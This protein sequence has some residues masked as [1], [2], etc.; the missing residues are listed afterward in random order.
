MMYGY[1][2]CPKCKNELIKRI[3]ENV[4][5]FVRYGEKCKICGE[6]LRLALTGE[7]EI[8]GTI[9]TIK[10]QVISDE[11]IYKRIITQVYDCEK[12]KATR[13][14]EDAGR[15]LLE[16]DV[17]HTYLNME[18]LDDIGITYDVEPNFPFTRQI[19][20]FC[21]DCGSETFYK[22][23]ETDIKENETDCY[24]QVGFFCEK[25]SKWIAMTYRSKME[26]DETKYK[27]KICLK[28]VD[29]EK[30]ICIKKMVDELVDKR[31]FS[32]S[33]IIFDNACNI[34]K[35][36]EELKKLS[37]DYNIEPPYPYKVVTHRQEWTEE[38][39]KMLM[40]MNPGLILDLEEMND[41]N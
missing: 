36:L 39:L 17:L 5:C 12:I 35:I 22:K 7:K 13:V 1:D 26:I 32:N 9:Y 3:Q 15:L 11:D 37:I 8:D 25:C 16:G 20:I 27:L 40:E 41:L 34:H 31:L 30:E 14:L 18:L 19:Y 23:A 21:P 29:C 24:I 33:I 4:E 10:S 2:I 38:E 6:R 28:N